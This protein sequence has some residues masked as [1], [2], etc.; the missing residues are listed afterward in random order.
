MRYKKLGITSHHFQF[1]AIVPYDMP[2]ISYQGNYR[3]ILLRKVPLRILINTTSLLNNVATTNRF[4]LN[5]KFYLLWS[6]RKTMPS[7]KLSGLKFSTYLKREYTYFINSID[8]AMT[9]KIEPCKTERK[10]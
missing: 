4:I 6:L 2:A 1:F 9:Y 7:Q 3:D 8:M 5:L 10:A